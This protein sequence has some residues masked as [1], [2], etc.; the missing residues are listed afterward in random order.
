MELFFLVPEVPM[1]PLTLVKIKTNKNKQIGKC[2][3]QTDTSNKS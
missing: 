2:E 3:R 1:E